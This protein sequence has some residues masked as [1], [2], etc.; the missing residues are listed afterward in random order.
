[1]WL[2]SNL[3][4]PNNT[5]SNEEILPSKNG[6]SDPDNTNSNEEIYDIEVQSQEMK[7]GKPMRQD[8]NIIGA[9]TSNNACGA[10]VWICKHCNKKFT[11]L[12]RRLHVYFLLF[13]AEEN[14]NK[15]V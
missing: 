7:N 10:K 1:M 3:L 12:Y 4:S 14:K 13:G 6:D 8:V 15:K 11:I 5:Y 9:A 2:W